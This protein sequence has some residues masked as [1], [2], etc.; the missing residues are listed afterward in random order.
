ME[1][2]SRSMFLPC[3]KLTHGIEGIGSCQLHDLIRD[4]GISKWMEENLVLTLEEGCSSN[5]QAT[6]RHLAI[7]GNWKG[8]RSEFESIVDMS[9]VRSVTVFVE[10]KSFYISDKMSLLQV[11][12]LEDTTRLRDHHLK[13]IGKLL[14]LRY[15]SL[16]GC[17][18]IYHLP[19]SLGNLRELQTLDVRGTNI[20]KL[21][22]S[23]INLQKLCN[24]RVG[25][26]TYDEIIS[27]QGYGEKGVRGHRASR[28]P[29]MLM[30]CCLFWCA[31]QLIEETG[32]SRRDVCT[33]IC[34]SL[35]PAVAMHLD[36]YGVLVPRGIRKLRPAY[37]GYCEH[38]TTREEHSA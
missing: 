6:M 17:H 15:L 2:I 7:N 29:L 12:D 5:S 1:L 9:C 19:G 31:P 27:Y 3:K 21:P 14:H 23:S 25:R 36:E 10:W 24:L 30:S 20:I 34:C 37:T 26:K 32:T 22:K 13:H 16:R 38:R 11:L 35:I 18:G 8:D 28:T 33:R 4:I